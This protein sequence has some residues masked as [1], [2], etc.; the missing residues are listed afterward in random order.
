M[1]IEDK[2]VT[3][4]ISGLK[5]LYGQDVPAA[6]VQLQKKK[7]EFDV[8]NMTPDEQLKFEIAQ[9]LGLDEKVLQKGWKSLTSKESGRIG[10]MITGRKRQLK[11]E[12]LKEN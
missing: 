10:G 4:V 8:H 3:S 9:E 11:E 6:Q 7:K 1:K 2:L 5:A 12:A